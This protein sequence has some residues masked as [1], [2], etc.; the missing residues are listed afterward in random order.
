MESNAKQIFISSAHRIDIALL[1]EKYRSNNG[2]LMMCITTDEQNAIMS[3]QNTLETIFT[4]LNVPI[5]NSKQ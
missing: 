2:R 1:I 3:H 5:P 4:A